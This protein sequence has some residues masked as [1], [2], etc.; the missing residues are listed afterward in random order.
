M[1]QDSFLWA[2]QLFCACV[3]IMAWSMLTTLIFRPENLIEFISE[4]KDE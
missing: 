2:A 3:A 4:G 1:T